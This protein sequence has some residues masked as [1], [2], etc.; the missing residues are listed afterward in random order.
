[1][2]RKGQSG[3]SSRA[4]GRRPRKAR[5]DPRVSRQGES[6]LRL[7]TRLQGLEVEVRLLRL[8]VAE[9][10]QAIVGEEYWVHEDDILEPTEE[11]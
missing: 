7:K 8:T 11:E 5:A 6:M 1:M 10:Y 3:A 2:A 4:R 9:C